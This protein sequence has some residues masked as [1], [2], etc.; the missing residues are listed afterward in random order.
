LCWAC[1]P[2]GPGIAWQAYSDQVLQQVADEKKPVIID[3]YADWCTPCRELEEVTFH[4]PGVVKQAGDHFV[5]IK[6]DVTRG[7]NPIHER[8]LKQYGVMGVPTVIFL[9]A[10]GKERTG[11]RLVDFLP[12]D[13]FLGHMSGIRVN[14]YS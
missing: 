11:L 7:G 12:P 5:M 8:L 14:Q 9:D 2:G 6:V 4:H 13:P 10:Q 3:F 1:S